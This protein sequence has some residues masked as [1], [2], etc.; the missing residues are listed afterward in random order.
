MRSRHSSHFATPPI[1][2]TP[3]VKRGPSAPTGLA[4]RT[5]ETLGAAAR[6]SALTAFFGSEG[7]RS[8]ST[9]AKRLENE[10]KAI[11]LLMSGT[12]PAAAAAA[13]GPL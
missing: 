1:M 9:A 3:S 13:T 7:P 4:A 11:A 5:G 6:L 2:S 12:I 8:A 10:P